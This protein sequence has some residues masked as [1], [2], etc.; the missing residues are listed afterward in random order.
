MVDHGW[1]DITS[2]SD[3]YGHYCMNIIGPE[4]FICESDNWE[5]CS[6]TVYDRWQWCRMRAPFVW[7]PL[8]VYCCV[9]QLTMHDAYLIPLIG[10][11][12]APAPHPIDWVWVITCTSSH[13]L[14]LCEHLHPIPLIGSGWSPAPHPID[15]V[16]ASTCTPSHWL[17]LGEHLH[18]IPLI[19]SMRAPAPHPI[20]WIWVPPLSLTINHLLFHINIKL[21]QVIY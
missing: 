6:A 8:F 19:G 4:S 1:L 20:D 21:L 18:P 7:R 3:I 13:W 17:D 14:G 5:H 11:G 2:W 10:S 12:R 9:G 16:Y 15:W